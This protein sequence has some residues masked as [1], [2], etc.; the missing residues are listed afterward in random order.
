MSVY[1]LG[2]QGDEVSRIQ[3]KLKAL[4]FYL[5]PVDG[6]FGGGTYGAV[7]AFQSSKDLLADGVVGPRTWKGLFR[8]TILESALSQSSLEYR[9]LA[10]TGSFET[11]KSIP[12][13]FAGLSGDFDGQGMSLGVLQ[14]NFGRGSLQPLLED[15]VNRYPETMES[16]FHEQLGVLLAALQSPKEE[17]MSFVRS[18]QHPVKHYLYDPWKGSFKTL[19]RTREF[20]EMQVKYAGALHQAAL[21]HCKEYGIWSE[22]AA[23]LMFDIKV[24]NGSISKLVKTQILSDIDRLGLDLSDRQRE[25]EKMKIIA[26]REAEAAKPAWVEDVRARKLCIARGGGKVHGISYDLAEQF[27]IGLERRDIDASSGH[28]KGRRPAGSTGAD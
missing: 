4:G 6:I 7:K 1:K 23:A 3:K 17:L 19:G 2:S 26:N 13:C 22:R 27:G 18:I 9:C 8:T 11:G 12:D 20:Q 14:W 15:M 28:R 21:R 5:G 16:V 25:V 10:L 24:Q